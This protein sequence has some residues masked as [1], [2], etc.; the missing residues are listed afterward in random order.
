MRDKNTNIDNFKVRNKPMNRAE[1]RRN[2]K[3]LRKIFNSDPTMIHEKKYVPI[4]CV[5]C[6]EKMKSIHDTHNPFPITEKCYAKEAYD[7]GNPNRSCSA[8]AS[9][10]LDARLHI[11]GISLK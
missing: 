8:C 1:R 3:M 5:I 4:N 11:L 6:G 10:V 9:K 2:N 7:T